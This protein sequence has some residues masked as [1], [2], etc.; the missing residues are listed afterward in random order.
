MGED[1]VD[2]AFIQEPKYRPDS[3]LRQEAQSIPLIDL[4]CHDMDAL[5]HDIRHACKQWG[6]FHIINHG[7]STESRHKMEETTRKFFGL[8]LDEKRKVRRDEEK[9]LGYYD[10]EHTKNVRDWK[11]VFDF[12]LAGNM[13][14][15]VSF[16]DGVHETET[17]ANVWPQQ[18]RRFR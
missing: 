7:V 17:H 2:I 15:P 10:T 9:V 1:I 4:S 8:S 18:P 16:Q 11:E 6:F 5:V 13:Q 14:L 12:T 3:T